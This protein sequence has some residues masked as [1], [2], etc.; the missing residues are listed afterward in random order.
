MSSLKVTAMLGVFLYY[1]RENE[2]NLN[3]IDNFDA[4]KNELK[5]SNKS[6]QNVIKTLL[7]WKFWRII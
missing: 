1:Q 4:E 5:V 6:Y 2:T 3:L 7:K